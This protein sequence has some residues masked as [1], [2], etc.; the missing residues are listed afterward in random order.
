M[1]ILL[2][3]ATV[4]FDWNG[5]IL[6]EISGSLRQNQKLVTCRLTYDLTVHTKRFVVGH[7]VA[8]CCLVCSDLIRPHTTT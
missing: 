1:T 7:F 2:L 6:W 5:L 4:L 3:R 8:T